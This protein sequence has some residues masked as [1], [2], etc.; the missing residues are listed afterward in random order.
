V[1]IVLLLA[2]ALIAAPAS[3]GEFKGDCGDSVVL[4]SERWPQLRARMDA[5]RESVRSG[6]LGAAVAAQREVVALQCH[7]HY[8]RYYLAELQVGAGHWGGAVTTLEGLYD[9]GVND[10]EDRLFNPGNP[11]HPL[12]ER[13]DFRRSALAARIEDKRVGHAARKDRFLAALAALPA[14]RK[15]A[16]PYVSRDVCP[17]ECCRYGDWTARADIEVV[18]T[19]G[20]DEVVGHL[21]SGTAFRGLTGDVH[22]A[23]RPIAVVHT[24]PAWDPPATVREGEIVFLLDGMGEGMFHIWHDGVV[25]IMSASGE[26]RDHC[27][28]PDDDCW[29][30]FLRPKPEDAEPVWWKKVELPDG[31]VGWMRDDRFDGAGG[32]G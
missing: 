8:Q 31:T 5:V 22:L 28:F 13:D 16:A 32:C 23:P 9:L 29:G 27:P 17:F 19:P 21:S 6:E 20:S 11:L 14:D 7:N 18:A 26:V 3:G 24:E 25:R 2:T 1:R 12:V 10:L 30:E 15:P 4:G